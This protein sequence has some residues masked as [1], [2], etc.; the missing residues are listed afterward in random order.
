MASI[1]DKIMEIEIWQEIQAERVEILRLLFS[2]LAMAAGSAWVELD[3]DFSARC[4]FGREARQQLKGLDIRAGKMSNDQV[5]RVLMY[6]SGKPTWICQ[7]HP[8]VQRVTSSLLLAVLKEKQNRG[9][10]PEAVDE[11]KR[12]QVLRGFH[13]LVW[14]ARDFGWLSLPAKRIRKIW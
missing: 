8:D 1:D 6:A 13:Q 5:A 2:G 11:L 10:W 4:A 3:R 12:R 9:G 14:A 7:H